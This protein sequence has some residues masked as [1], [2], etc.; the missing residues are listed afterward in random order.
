MRRIC[1]LL[2]IIG[3]AISHIN[4]QRMPLP[5]KTI[6]MIDYLPKLDSLRKLYGTRKFIAKEFELQTLI[7]LSYFP[8]L[9]NMVIDFK[10][11]DIGTTM[12]CRPDVISVVRGRS[13]RFYN[14]FIDN[15]AT[16]TG[17]ILLKDVPFNAQVGVIA[18]ELC[19]ILDYEKM[20]SGDLIKMGV[21]YSQ[22]KNRADIEKRVDR[23]TIKRG[24][25]WQLWDWS[26]FILN[27]SKA[28][29]AYK[30]YKKKTYLSPEEIKIEMLKDKQYKQV[31]FAKAF[32]R[33]D[34]FIE[35]Y[36][37][38]FGLCLAF[39]FVPD[40]RKTVLHRA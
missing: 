3:L 1:C 39:L 24:L 7:A 19:H 32:W 10:Y 13:G 22:K 6:T 27:R 20:S 34:F 28:T 4:A 8:E 37:V 35:L 16:D 5:V 2:L 30:Y 11:Q 40:F 17:N 36:G 12:A 14:I 33:N 26:D 31:R 23:L 29:V 21:E 15:N 25:G 9:K 38:L 18:H